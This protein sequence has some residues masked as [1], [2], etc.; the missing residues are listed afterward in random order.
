MNEDSPPRRRDYGALIGNVAKPL[1]AFGVTMALG[2][3]AIWGAVLAKNEANS[4]AAAQA[5]H[6][7]IMGDDP[8]LQVR[9]NPHPLAY[10][11]Y[12]ENNEERIRAYGPASNHSDMVVSRFSLR[13]NHAELIGN[14]AELD[15]AL[16]QCAAEPANCAPGI[17]E[18]STMLEVARALPDRLTQSSFVN[19]WVNTALLYDGVVANDKLPHRSLTEALSDGRAVC[20]EQ[21][22]LKLHALNAIGFPAQDVRYVLG[23]VRSNAADGRL[24]DSGHAVVLARHGRVNWVLNNDGQAAPYAQV[25]GLAQPLVDLS[26][27]A[28]RQDT[29]HAQGTVF[30]PVQAMNYVVAANYGAFDQA[31]EQAQTQ[32]AQGASPFVTL[33]DRF[34]M[35]EPELL[36]RATQSLY[37]ATQMRHVL[38]GQRSDYAQKSPALLPDR[39]PR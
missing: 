22:Q 25:P 10:A 1:A 20:D 16:R 17:R 38:P 27:N 5:A 15:A 33:Q 11:G 19:A 8:S 18:Y 26:F 13:Q 21:A 34:I 4:R 24:Q 7:A 9:A 6:I 12:A 14:A 2:T 36:E 29:V 32:R 28:L 30:R 37:A 31:V 35:L 23:F 3:S 39:S